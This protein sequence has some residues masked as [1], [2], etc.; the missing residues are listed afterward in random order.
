MDC[1]PGHFVHCSQMTFQIGFGRLAVF[2]ASIPI[3]PSACWRMG[4]EEWMEQCISIEHVLGGPGLGLHNTH[5]AING[6]RYQ[7]V[8]SFWF[9]VDCFRF[10]GAMEKEEDIDADDDASH[11]VGSGTNEKQKTKN[12]DPKQRSNFHYTPN[13]FRMICHL[14][15][16]FTS[17]IKKL[18]WKHAFIF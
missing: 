14:I 6:S 15:F 18:F 7:G 9:N 3:R 13:S 16:F 2:D 4:V 8:R 1:L 10:V 5:S 12:L 11:R 17:Y